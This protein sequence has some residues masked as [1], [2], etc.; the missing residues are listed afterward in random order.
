MITYEEALFW[1]TNPEEFK[2][3]LQGISSTSG[4][5]QEQI[6]EFTFRGDTGKDSVDSGGANWAKNSRWTNS[7][8][9]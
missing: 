4:M 2:L 3:R 6:E 5:T 8:D 7:N 9:N 1:A